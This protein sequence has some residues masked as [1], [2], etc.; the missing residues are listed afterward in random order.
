MSNYII[1]NGE[2]YHFGVKGMKWGVRKEYYADKA[3]R[4]RLANEAR[5]SGQWVNLYNKKARK[6]TL[7][8]VRKVDR[9][10]KKHNEISDKTKLAIERNVALQ[11]DKAKAVKK[12]NS[13]IENLQRHVDGMIS[14]Y[15]DVKI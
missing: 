13:D 14:K 4:K 8:T 12:L 5:K 6:D 2:L 10:L 1:H 11:K 7:S 3:K 9:D 15:K